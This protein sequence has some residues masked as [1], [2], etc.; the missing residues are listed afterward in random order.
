[1]S[2]KPKCS[3]CNERDVFS[4]GLCSGCYGRNWRKARQRERDAAI[5]EQ[6]PPK[7]LTSGVT[8]EELEPVA[9][10]GEIVHD[11][12]PDPRLVALNPAEMAEARNN[13][14]AHFEQ[15]LTTIERDIIEANRVRSKRPSQTG[16]S[17][18][19][20]IDTCP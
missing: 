9:I 13:M 2:S 16:R 15:K 4:K 1:M 17:Y 10:D 8:A 7:Q 14:R 20:W 18:V 3:Q 11:A 5:A 12:P 6:F 19:S